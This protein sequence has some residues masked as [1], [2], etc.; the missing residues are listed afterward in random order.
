[1]PLPNFCAGNGSAR[2][3]IVIT[4]ATNDIGQFT[5]WENSIDKA[6]PSARRGDSYIYLANEVEQPV[7]AR[8]NND[9]RLCTNPDSATLAPV[10]QAKLD[11]DGKS[12][13]VAQPLPIV[14]NGRQASQRRGIDRDTESGATHATRQHPARQGIEHNLDFVTRFDIA[15]IVFSEVCAYPDVVDAD[16]RH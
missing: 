12:L 7:V 4:D 3:N 15:E 5:S 8:V 11:I 2:I 9:R 6:V 14:V 13:G 10:I 16:E 1:M